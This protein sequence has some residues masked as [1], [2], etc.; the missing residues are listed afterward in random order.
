MA[1]KQN[2][3]HYLILQNTIFNKKKNSGKSCINLIKIHFKNCN[4][5]V[6]DCS[7]QDQNQ[8]RNVLIKSDSSN[9]RCHISKTIN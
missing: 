6:E 7:K 8:N 2:K 3:K 5:Y 4:V 1:K 9:I